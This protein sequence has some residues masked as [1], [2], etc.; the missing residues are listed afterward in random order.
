MATFIKAGFWQKLCNPCNGYKGWLNLDQLIQDVVGPPIPGPPG[1]IGP[2]GPT[3]TLAGKYGSFYDT[4]TQLAPLID[5]IPQIYRVKFNSTDVAAT[6]GFSVVNDEF[7][8]P[9]KILATTT[10]VYNFQW[11]AQ[12]QRLSGGSSKQAVVWI[13]INDTD[14][15]GST[16]HVTL[17]ANAKYLLPAWN[18]FIQLNAGDYLQLMWSQDD[19]IEILYEGPSLS[20]PYYP[21]TASIIATINQIG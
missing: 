17:Q 10:G 16:G 5:G 6:N 19:N 12:L 20:P 18:Y 13:R 11:S 2:Q 14:V 8:N 15:I 7:G 3:G 1:P 21:G 9:T 4:T